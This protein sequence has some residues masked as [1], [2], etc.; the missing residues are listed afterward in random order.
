M[1]KINSQID[2]K[3]TQGE[4]AT[5]PQKQVFLVRIYSPNKENN[6]TYIW[7]RYLLK[8]FILAPEKAGFI[9]LLE[10]TKF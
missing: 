3:Q 4:V 10:R 1:F 7:L 9:K 5:N 8:L 2:I 6:F